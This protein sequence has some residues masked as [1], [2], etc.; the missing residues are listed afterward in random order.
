MPVIPGTK[1]ISQSG[2][3]FINAANADTMMATCRYNT[4]RPNRKCRPK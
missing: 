2:G 4:A 1:L 3:F